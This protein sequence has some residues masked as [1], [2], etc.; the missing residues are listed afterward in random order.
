MFEGPLPGGQFRRDCIRVNIVS[1]YR[2]Y[3]HTLSMSGWGDLQR[4]IVVTAGAE[5]RRLVSPDFDMINAA[6]ISYK[7]SL[8]TWSVV[9]H[10]TSE[11][12]TEGRVCLGKRSAHKRRAVTNTVIHCESTTPAES[13]S[14]H[15]IIG[16]SFLCIYAC[17]KIHWTLP[18]LTSNKD[19]LE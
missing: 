5:E 11:W 7:C 13:K 10:R 8:S 12:I 18:Y 14:S 3:D 15:T 16:A 17:R 4:T 19:V 2:N 6:K 9:Y 1:T